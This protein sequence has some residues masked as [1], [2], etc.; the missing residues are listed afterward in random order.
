MKEKLNFNLP[1]MLAGL[2]GFLLSMQAPAGEPMLRMA[3]TTSTQN[4]GLLDR[5]LP[6][7]SKDT[8][9]QVQVLAVGT[10]KALKMGRDGDVAVVMVHARKAEQAFVDDGSGVDRRGFME[11]DFLLAGPA[12]DP[13]GIKQAGSAAAAMQRIFSSQS[14]FISRGDDSGTHKKEQALW[15]QAGVHPGGA[16]YLEAGQGMGKVL[17]MASEMEAYT[18]TDRGTWLV[19][20]AKLQLDPLY[21]SD[22][23]LANP[24]GI[25]AVNPQKHPDIRHDLAKQLIDWVCTPQAQGIIRD[26]QV[27]GEAL[28]KPTCGQ[29]R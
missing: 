27:K 8:G 26:Y 17:Q 10:G 2:L 11:N 22:P 1:L 24:Y 9:I 23:I 25:I 28:F 20:Q 14:R 3:T 16:W 12:T 4:S 5:L 18:L 6:A 7:F 21:A 15:G 29:N 19:H 13:A